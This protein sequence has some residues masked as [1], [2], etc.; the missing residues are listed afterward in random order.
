MV[1]QRGSKGIPHAFELE[2]DSS[3][4]SSSLSKESGKPS[5]HSL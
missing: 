3:E 2:S 1:E 5:E 4:F